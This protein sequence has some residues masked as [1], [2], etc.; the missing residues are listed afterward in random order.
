MRLSITRLASLLLLIALLDARA[1]CAQHRT[2]SLDLKT[3]FSE[4]LDL[5]AAK[6]GALLLL[7]ESDW[8]GVTEFGEDY[9]LW[10]RHPVHERRGDSIVVTLDAELR[11]G[12]LF[13][14]GDLLASRRI[15]V[16]YALDD[17]WK[18]HAGASSVRAVVIG[19]SCVAAA[20]LIGKAVYPAA[21]TVAERVVAGLEMMMPGDYEQMKLE[22]V[23]VGAEVV[24]AAR[25]MVE[26]REMREDD[27]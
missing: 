3:K 24:R 25:E 27:R 23:V 21:T 26:E 13:E 1:A 6:N 15:T 8:A 4:K 5:S 17:D 16:A 14:E 9:A 22:A 19:E 20:A 18:R 7:M 2:T 12:S 11:E 10:L